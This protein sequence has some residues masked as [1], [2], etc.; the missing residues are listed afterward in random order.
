METP[1]ECLYIVNGIKVILGS[2]YRYTQL[3]NHNLYVD[4][5]VDD[6]RSG[7]IVIFMAKFELELD[8]H[9]WTEG[10]L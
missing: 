8:Q 10:N 1:K 6:R 5:K 4:T 2:F 9:E 3:N 7:K